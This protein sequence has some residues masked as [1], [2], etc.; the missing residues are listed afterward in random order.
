MARKNACGG[1]GW[2]GRQGK[3]RPKKKKKKVAVPGQ[4]AYVCSAEDI[5]LF[6]FESRETCGIGVEAGFDKG[7]G[8]VG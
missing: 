5:V 1:A 3:A 4:G 8:E 6:V 2:R 7:S